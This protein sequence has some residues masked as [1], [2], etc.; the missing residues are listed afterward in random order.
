M[1]Q[2]LYLNVVWFSHFSDWLNQQH[3]LAMITIYYHSPITWTSR[4]IFVK[5]SE[6][7]FIVYS[8]LTSAHV[9]IC[10]VAKYSL[11]ISRNCN[12]IVSLISHSKFLVIEECFVVQV[13]PSTWTDNFLCRFWF[14]NSKDNPCCSHLHWVLN[15]CT[16]VSSCQ[17]AISSRG[18]FKA[19]W[20]TNVYL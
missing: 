3:F 17:K 11:L 6:F 15:N 9:G 5:F 13:T 12:K 4:H 1:K 18:C 10:G 2:F 20:L 14:Q 19:E 16:I 7:R 8:L